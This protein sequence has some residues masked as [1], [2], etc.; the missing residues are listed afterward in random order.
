M[1]HEIHDYKCIF[2]LSTDDMLLVTPPTLNQSLCLCVC[3]RACVCVCVRACVRACVCV[4]VCVSSPLD[5]MCS[6]QLSCHPQL[7]FVWMLLTSCR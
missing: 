3:V 7:I 2:P 1:C 6:Q 5:Q 4:C